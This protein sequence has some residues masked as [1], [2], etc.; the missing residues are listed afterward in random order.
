[1]DTSLNWHSSSVLQGNNIDQVVFIKVSVEANCKNT[2]WKLKNCVYGLS[3]AALSW[4]FSVAEK[5][6][7]LNCYR[8]TVDYEIFT[9]YE[10]KELSGVILSHVD[11]FLY[12]GTTSFIDSVINPLCAKFEICNNS[13]VFIFYLEY[14]IVRE[15]I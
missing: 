4:Y 14:K 9:W 5:L 8:F 1:M 12:T 7:T 3:G 11:D 2:L 10:N 6:N 13:R 15:F